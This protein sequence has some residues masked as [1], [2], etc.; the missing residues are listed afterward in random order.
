MTLL[1]NNVKLSTAVF[2]FF[3]FFFFF[4]ALTS[5]CRTL[6][7]ASILN[8]PFLSDAAFKC[9]ASCRRLHKVRVEG[10][11]SA[12][13]VRTRSATGGLHGRSLALFLSL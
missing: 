7:N 6:K 13:P 12:C 3:S 5:E 1:S 10:K 9:L 2:L 8:S 11:S 4:Q